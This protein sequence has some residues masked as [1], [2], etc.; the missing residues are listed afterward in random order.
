VPSANYFHG[1]E[2][3]GYS[4]D[5]TKLLLRSYTGNSNGDYLVNAVAGTSQLVSVGGPGYTDSRGMS[6]N[7]LYV[8]GSY[9]PGGNQNRGFIWS[10][11]G[12]PVTGIGAGFGN[13]SYLSHVSNDGTMALGGFNSNGNSQAFVWKSAGSTETSFAQVANLSAGL[14]SYLTHVKADLSVALLHVYGNNSSTIYRWSPAIGQF[15]HLDL[16]AVNANCDASGLSADG[17]TVIAHAGSKVHRWTAAGWDLD[18]TASLT[19]VQSA[20]SSSNNYTGYGNGLSTNLSAD[21]KALVGYYN[22]GNTSK[23]FFWS[24]TTGAI[25]LLATMPNAQQSGPSPIIS[26]DGKVVFGGLYDNNISNI[27]SNSYFNNF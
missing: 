26:A 12:T 17:S 15:T 25:D 24:T 20:Y 13:D 6:A 5:G 14:N 27:F 19:G 9:S 2:L 8:V 10:A 16:S 7:G 3:F 21:G 4:N 22:I 1:G 11:T 23:P 18:L